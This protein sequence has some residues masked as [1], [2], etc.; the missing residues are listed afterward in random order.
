MGVLYM[1]VYMLILNATVVQIYY[2]YRPT[3]SA[4][5]EIRVCQLPWTRCVFIEK[6]YILVGFEINRYLL[7]TKS[8]FI[9]IRP[10]FTTIVLRSIGEYSITIT[11]DILHIIYR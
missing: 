2:K 9:E 10:M 1:H 6:K 7:T 5:F 4:E 11:I 3:P 8:E